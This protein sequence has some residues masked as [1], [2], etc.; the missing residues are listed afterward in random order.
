MTGTRWNVTPMARLTAAIYQLGTAGY[1]VAEINHGTVITYHYASNE[2]AI[3]RWVRD[4]GR[5][6]R[7][8]EPRKDATV[9]PL[10]K[11]GGAIG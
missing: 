3:R 1:W 4:S 7:V 6:V 2:S 11:R 10:A 5:R 8:W 9:S